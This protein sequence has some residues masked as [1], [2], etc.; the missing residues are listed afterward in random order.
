MQV[1][2]SS[3]LFSM[4]FFTKYGSAKKGRAMLT[5]SAAPLAKT[6]SATAG[7]F[8]RLVVQRGIESSPLSF[9]VTHVKALQLRFN[10][11]KMAEEP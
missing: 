1:L 3:A 8:K 4:A 6:S 9:R 2:I 5:M 10:R 11:L 7:M